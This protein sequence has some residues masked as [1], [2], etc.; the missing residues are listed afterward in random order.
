[1][2]YVSADESMLDV[3]INSEAVKQSAIE[4]KQYIKLYDK[5]AKVNMV[6][7]VNNIDNN[8]CLLRFVICWWRSIASI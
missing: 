6:S 2:I 7:F 1:M 4:L 3:H 5:D 8:L